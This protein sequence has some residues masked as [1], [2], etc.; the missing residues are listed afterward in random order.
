[1]PAADTPKIPP[2]AQEP[3]PDG[4]FNCGICPKTYSRRSAPRPVAGIFVDMARR[5][6][7]PAPSAVHPIDQPR[8]PV[9]AQTCETCAQKKLRC[10]MT[11]SACTRC[12]QI[13]IHCQYPATAVPQPQSEALSAT[14]AD[15]GT[16]QRSLLENLSHPFEQPPGIHGF[17]SRRL[18]SIL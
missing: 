9:E 18:V 11:R 7:R 12:L 10:S 5:P 1:M 17:H 15:P 6:T 13:G 2:A 16:I 14:P 3:T 4:E 8:T